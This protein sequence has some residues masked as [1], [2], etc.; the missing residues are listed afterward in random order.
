LIHFYKRSHDEVM[1][2]GAEDTP[3]A[4]PSIGDSQ[5]ED[6]LY[7]DEVAEEIDLVEG[8]A[9]FRA[10]WTPMRGTRRR[11]SW[12]SCPGGSTSWRR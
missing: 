6:E 5:E 2:S 11:R 1:R 3:P 7:E 12:W 10:T 8:E 4:S 9:D